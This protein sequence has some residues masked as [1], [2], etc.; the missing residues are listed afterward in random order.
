MVRHISFFFFLM[1]YLF[2]LEQEEGQ[3]ER[4]KE[5]PQVDSW[6]SVELEAGLDLTTLR[7]WPQNYDLS[8]N[9]ETDTKPT[10]ACRYPGHIGFYLIISII[11]IKFLHWLHI[12]PKLPY[13]LYIFKDF[14]WGMPRWFSGWASVFRSGCDPGIRD[15]VLYQAPCG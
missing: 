14:V 5:N 6:L 9:Q 13:G 12:S 15:W 2:I 8:Q 4:E 1:I 10:E 7:A 11:F 3:R